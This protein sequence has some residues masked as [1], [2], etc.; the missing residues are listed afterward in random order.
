M[1]KYGLRAL[2]LLYLLF[3]LVLPVVL[4]GWRTFE[5]G[6]GPVL[7]ALTTPQAQSAFRVTL[8]VAF[9]AVLANTVFGVG[10]AILLVR[11]DFPGKRL[12]NALIDLPMAVSP[13]VVGLALILV[14]G[15]FAPVGGWLENLGVQIIFSVPGMV[16]A[17]VFISLPLVIREVIPVL[18]ELGDE[19]EQAA[20]TLGAGPWQTFRRI[21]IPGIRWA[22]AYGVVLCLAR[23]LG[24]YGAVAVVSGRLVEKTQTLT[25]FVEERFQNFDEASAFAAA[26][27]LALVAVVTLLL[28]KIL[29]PKG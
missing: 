14:Y 20:R 26:T 29:R 19:Q 22:L 27:A 2:A 11:H 8:I 13:V 23:A 6:L 4:I 21:T 18:E 17:A 10:T 24:E 3:L 5:N 1:A 12:L 9:W 7:E 28:T 15:R 25:L 16:M